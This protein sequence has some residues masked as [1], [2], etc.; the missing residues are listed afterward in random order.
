MRNVTKKDIDAYTDRI[1]DLLKKQNYTSLYT[2]LTREE[3]KKLYEFF[4][5][6]KDWGREEAKYDIYTKRDKLQDINEKEYNEMDDELKQLVIKCGVNPK[7]VYNY[8][9]NYLWIDNRIYYSMQ[10]YGTLQLGDYTIS[11]NYQHPVDRDSEEIDSFLDEV[12]DMKYEK[13]KN[14]QARFMVYQKIDGEDECI[15]KHSEHIHFGD[16]ISYKDIQIG[17]INSINSYRFDLYSGMMEKE[18]CIARNI[19]EI[20]NFLMSFEELLTQ[21]LEKNN[22]LI[23]K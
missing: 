12:Q 19:N 22:K 8:S 4:F 5:I 2:K 13:S 20:M 1:L 6:L 23:L 15:Y 21:N 17:H 18:A 3:R 10:D 9:R 11:V 7:E 14:G 16:Y